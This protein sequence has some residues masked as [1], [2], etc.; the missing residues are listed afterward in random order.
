MCD[1]VTECD[2]GDEGSELA[3]QCMF[4]RIGGKA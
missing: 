1:C 3:R 2:S 4:S